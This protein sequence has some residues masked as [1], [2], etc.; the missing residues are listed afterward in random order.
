MD[1]FDYVMLMFVSV[2]QVAAIVIV[3][4]GTLYIVSAV[5]PELLYTILGS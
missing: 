2:V 5:T 3:V 4:W 1:A